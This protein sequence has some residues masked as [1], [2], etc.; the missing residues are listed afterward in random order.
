MGLRGRC[1]CVCV[2][3]CVREFT[4][5]KVVGAQLFSFMGEKDLVDIKSRLTGTYTRDFSQGIFFF[6]ERICPP[7]VFPGYLFL[8]KK[9]GLPWVNL[10][11]LQ[12]LGEGHL[13]RQTLRK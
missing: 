11:I 13:R 4:F 3:V 10:G 2:C 7:G 1:V 6:Q 9:S 8:L 5:E 12:P